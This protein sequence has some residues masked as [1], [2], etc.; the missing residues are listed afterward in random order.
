VRQAFET[1]S[2]PV[3]V[4]VDEESRT[5]SAY[6]F[7]A[8]RRAV[9]AAME[10]WDHADLTDVLTRRIGVS[11]AEAEEIASSVKA[12]SAGRRLASAPVPPPAEHL[13]SPPTDANDLE[14]AGLA[15]RF[16]AVLLDSIIVFLPLAI[17]VGLLYGGG[18][19]ERENGEASA[20]VIVFGKA[21]LAV[22]A[23]CLG[24]YIL[25]EAITGMT[26]GKRMVGIRVVADDGHHVGLNAA[27]V[28]NLLRLIDGF[29]FYLV[30]AIFVLASRRGQRLGDHIA[31][32]LVVRR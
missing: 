20:G 16:V 24:Y 23:L 22:L 11:Q 19:S 25:C 28:R 30:G 8:E 3:E 13:P 27:V 10:S 21:D 1:S 29:C 14:E 26:L 32:T 17:V 15:L 9:A 6:R 31:A 4:I 5:V 18:Y 2:G 7:D 12:S